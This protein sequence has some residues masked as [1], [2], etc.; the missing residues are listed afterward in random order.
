MGLTT[1]WFSGEATPIA[2]TPYATFSALINIP[3]AIGDRQGIGQITSVSSTTTVNTALIMPNIR[4]PNSYATILD[5]NDAI[6]MQ[7]DARIVAMLPSTTNQPMF[8]VIFPAGPQQIEIR[9]YRLD[10]ASYANPF[11]IAFGMEINTP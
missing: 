9:C 3:T 8:N 11:I 6:V 4:C 10:G 5:A 7:G 2:G 1:L